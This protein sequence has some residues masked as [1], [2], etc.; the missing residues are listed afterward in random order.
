V[1]I[2]LPRLLANTAGKNGLTAPTGGKKEKRKKK[3]RRGGSTGHT[4]AA[5]VT[6]PPVAYHAPGKTL[7]LL[8]RERGEKKKKGEKEGNRRPRA[9]TNS[10]F[11][12]PIQFFP[13]S[14]LRKGC[15]CKVPA[16]KEEKR[17]KRERSTN[18]AGRQSGI[19]V[20]FFHYLSLWG[21][22][23]ISCE[24]AARSSR[25]EKGKKGGGGKDQVPQHPGKTV[26]REAY[27]GREEK[28]KGR[29]PVI[30]ADLPL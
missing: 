7:H 20:G 4:E 17:K 2:R 5:T 13:F 16:T 21:V 19:G 23:S 27:L 26:P 29:G 3:K 14:P 25:E 28:K 30:D 15:P 9:R 8:P 18:P 10:R 1:L 11:G 12:L 24:C 22:W 6:L